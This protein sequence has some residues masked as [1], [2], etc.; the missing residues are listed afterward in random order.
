LTIGS[1]VGIPFL[2][3]QGGDT[4]AIRVLAKENQFILT[5]K[6]TT[7]AFEVLK[8][9]YLRHLYYGKKTTQIPTPDFMGV[10]FS[11]YI[12]QYNPLYSPDSLPCE[13]S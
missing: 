11:P 4:M 5:T 3:Q 10:S 13:I 9:Q 7:Y 1:S 2:K 6:N 12:A 8:G